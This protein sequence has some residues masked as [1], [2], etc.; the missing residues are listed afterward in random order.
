VRDA[1]LGEQPVQP[2][3]A[4]RVG[5]AERVGVRVADLADHVPVGAAGRQGERPARRDA[6]QPPLGIELVEQ[7][8]Q[9]VLGGAA[10]VEEDKSALGVGG[11]RTDA[12]D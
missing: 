3:A 2:G 11:G 7:R 12:V 9:V 8:E 5:R 1:V 10:A 4:G 6:Q